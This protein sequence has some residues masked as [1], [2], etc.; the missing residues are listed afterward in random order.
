MPVFPS[1][2]GDGLMEVDLDD[3][4]VVLEEEMP[5]VVLEEALV[6]TV[7]TGDGESSSAD[8]EWPI[9]EVCN[10]HNLG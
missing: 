9:T 6:T 7:T 2:A 4:E 3:V 1:A 8:Q 5:E 10:K